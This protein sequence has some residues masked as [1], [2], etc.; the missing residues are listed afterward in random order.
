MTDVDSSDKLYLK[1]LNVPYFNNK[2]KSTKKI[3]FTLKCLG[4]NL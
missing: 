3:P 4:L 2:K 1:R